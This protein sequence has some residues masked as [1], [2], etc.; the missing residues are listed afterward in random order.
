MRILTLLCA[1]LA[2]LTLH[3][4]TVS[5][6]NV[7]CNEDAKVAIPLHLDEAQGL[8]SVE[9]VITYDP[10]VLVPAGVRPGSLASRFNFAFDA[11]EADGQTT[12]VCAAEKDITEA[13]GGVL[14]VLDFTVRPGSEGLYSDLA[15][16]KVTL[17]E[18]T[19]T[20]DLRNET[21][22]QGGL[23]RPLAKDGVCD[24]AARL[25]DGPLTVA[26]GTTL[27]TLALAE[28]DALQASADA[29]VVVTDALTAQGA[30]R[31]EAPAEGWAPGRYTLLRTPQSLAR[32][33]APDFDLPEHST[34]TQTTTDGQTTY[35]LEVG[36][37]T[38]LAQ[39]GDATYTTIDAIPAGATVTPV[40]GSALFTTKNTL[41]RSGGKVLSG[42]EAYNATRLL[43]GA[44]T[45]SKTEDS[46]S[47]TLTYDYDLGLGGLEV[48]RDETDALTLYALVALRD[49]TL[50]ET[51]ER[52]LTGK[53]VIVTVALG[54][55]GTKEYAI[56]NPT[57]AYDAKRGTHLCPVRIPWAD[58]LLGTN[59]LTVRIQNAD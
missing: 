58:F 8:A 57:F 26:A 17:N 33:A 43:G 14:A 12:V 21:T 35:T 49:D 3:A 42:T 4:H 16:A 10:L 52:P 2:A 13:G 39:S 5:L 31:V 7:V 18:R 55:G 34:L 27:S 1:A 9:A 53:Q 28:G 54:P 40:A 29:P 50:T 38:V 32:A 6:G 56:T 25:G 19:M 51:T 15:L 46:G 22:P 45:A 37:G 20:L 44:F 47:T 24:T 59:R 30:I 36:D 11:L 41:A 48:R 23:L